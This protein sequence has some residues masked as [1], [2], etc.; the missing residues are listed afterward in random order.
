[1]NF[2]KLVLSTDKKSSNQDQWQKD[3]LKFTEDF[4]RW[5]GFMRNVYYI[6]ED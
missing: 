4:K 6:Y 2:L 3:A 1:M 5:L